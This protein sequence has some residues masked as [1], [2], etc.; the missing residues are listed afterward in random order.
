MER[1]EITK[2]LLKFIKKY[3]SDSE[4]SHMDI[5]KGEIELKFNFNHTEQKNVLT[6]FEDNISIFTEYTE[7]TRRDILE[8]NEIFIRFDEDGIYFGKT[9][10]DYTASNAA[11]YYVLNRYLDEM[12]EEL[13]EKIRFYQENYLY[14]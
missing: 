9:G 8:I 6:F 12:V 13:P 4:I 3:Y 1:Q 2:D 14:Q 7:D 5:P 10:Y 11:A